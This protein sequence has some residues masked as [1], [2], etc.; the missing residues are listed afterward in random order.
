MSIKKYPNI[1]NIQPGNP[2][3]QVQMRYFNNAGAGHRVRVFEMAESGH[4]IE[5]PVAATAVDL[6]D[7]VIGVDPE[8][9]SH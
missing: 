7:L 5:F 6:G 4:L 8:G 9:S 1:C 2:A 3:R